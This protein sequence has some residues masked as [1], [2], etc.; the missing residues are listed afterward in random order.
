MKF[1]DFEILLLDQGRSMKPTLEVYDNK[2]K[3]KQRHA[4][5]EKPNMYMNRTSCA[6]VRE[7]L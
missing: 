1:L 6:Q 3:K 2:V 7:L 4:I 5:N